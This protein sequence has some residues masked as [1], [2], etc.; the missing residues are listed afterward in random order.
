MRR[1]KNKSAHLWRVLTPG[2]K[3]YFIHFKYID[4]SFSEN[5]PI[6]NQYKPI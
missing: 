6:I 1:V 5:Q 4:D 2:R 3:K